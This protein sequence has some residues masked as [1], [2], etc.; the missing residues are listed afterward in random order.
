M[1]RAEIQVKGHI[2]ENWSG[3]FEEFEITYTDQD[4]TILTGEVMDQAALY[5]VI[6]KLRDVGL[7]LLSVNSTEVE[8]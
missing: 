1:L 5:G 4:E 3:W 6:A 8:E 2:A 7:A